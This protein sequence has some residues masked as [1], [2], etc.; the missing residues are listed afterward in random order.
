VATGAADTT[1]TTGERVAGH[2]RE[3]VGAY[4][5]RLEVLADQLL[6][7]GGWV[8][9]IMALP[10]LAGPAGLLGAGLVQFLVTP[11]FA[12]GGHARF[13]LPLLPFI[14]ILAAAFLDRLRPRVAMA[15]GAAA[16]LGLAATAWIQRPDYYR[17]EDGVFPELV[18]VGEWLRPHVTPETV[19]Y[20]RKPYAAFYAGAAFRAI[21]MG[22][23]DQILD[24]IVRDGGDYLV[25]DQAVVDF[26]RPQLLPLVLDKAV[27]WNEPRLDPVHMNGTYQDRRTLVYRVLRPGGPKSFVDEREIKQQIGFIEHGPAHFLH[28]ILAM[29]KKRWEVAAG[30]FA[31]AVQQDSTNSIAYN[32]RA[33]CLLQ[34][35]RNLGAAE[36]DA[37]KAVELE[38]DNPDYL[39]TLVEVLEAAGKP[40]EAA[41]FRSRMNRITGAGSPG[42]DA[43]EN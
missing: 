30:E 8:V 35:N 4:P 43:P 1:I 7:H 20:G 25:V 42:S 34:A 15:L 19:V 5:R 6:S 3:S 13:V 27:V 2:W 18:E 21:P 22:T 16:V 36:K 41:V 39:D 32:N 9:P 40:E 28:G 37:R 31:Y 29:R 24:A 26:F 38:P 14:W 10:A 17:N 11:L 33:W 12:L 23:Y